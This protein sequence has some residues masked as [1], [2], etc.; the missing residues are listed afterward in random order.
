LFPESETNFFS[1]EPPVE[2]VFSKDASGH[3]TGCVVN[4]QYKAQRVP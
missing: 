4:G 3:I 1:E 2:I